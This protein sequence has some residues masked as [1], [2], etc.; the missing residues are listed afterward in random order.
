MKV[1]QG[2]LRAVEIA[3]HADKTFFD[4]G[5]AEPIL[6]AALLYQRQHLPVPTLEQAECAYNGFNGPHATTIQH[7]MTE[8]VRRMYDAPEPEVPE[9]VKDLLPFP[10]DVVILDQGLYRRIKAHL[11]DVATEA[12]RRGRESKCH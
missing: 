5:D 9:A 1:P 6:E 2:M 10:K 3:S 4:A 7:C 11:D 12:Y 8:W